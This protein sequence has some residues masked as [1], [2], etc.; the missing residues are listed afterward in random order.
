M[1]RLLP[2]ALLLA[3]C[4]EK[5]YEE[6]LPQIVDFEILFPRGYEV[7]TAE[8]PL[9][10]PSAVPARVPIRIVARGADGQPF[11]QFNGTVRLDV[12][13]GEI[14]RTA[15]RVRVKDGVADA[16]AEIRYAFGPTRI[17]VEDAGEDPEL[18]CANEKDDDEDDLVDAADP[19]CGRARE[20]APAH[21]TQA[22]GISP[23]LRFAEPRIREL[24][25]APRCTTDTPLGG[26]TV[27]IANGKFIVTGTTQAGLYVTDLDGP[28]GGHN[29]VFLFT[30]S[31]PG[32]VRRGDR[33]CS[34]SGNA[35]EF[36]GNTQ[37]NF[38]SFELADTNRNRKID[39][40]D[41]VPCRLV[42]PGDIDVAAL[43]PPV[44]L[45]AEHLLGMG[46]EV[47]ADFY[48]FCAP[49]DAEIP[50][51]EDATDC[52]AARIALGMAARQSPIDCRRDNFAME[53]WEHALVAFDDVTISKHYVECDYNGDERIDRTRGEQALCGE[54]CTSAGCAM[55]CNE[56]E[57][58]K[59]CNEDALCTI[60]GSLKQFGQFGVGV[61]CQGDS[62]RAKF[63][64]ST[65]DT[66]GGAGYDP[67][68]HAGERLT[69]VVGHLRQTQPGPGVETIW[70]VEP[71]D[72]A[73]FISGA[74]Q[75]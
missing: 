40:G 1:R 42:D 53:P 75:P 67:K 10:F 41:I 34:I 3:A 69:R 18:D 6:P 37:L 47:P 32:D 9:P 54:V 28:A 24:Q 55:I 74:P 29:S 49:G 46:G 22:T 72:A 30:H 66:L 12:E 59:A 14:P 23:S 4:G 63:Y 61:G 2:I 56:G 33:L 70:I 45:A 31:S 57:C 48:R 39:D 68:A 52:N 25:L 43:P 5:S 20:P 21:A 51:L 71:R 19:D 36:I 73:D 35:A 58:E 13:P 65:R 7:G 64:V 44:T 16:T 27:T 60:E 17:W 26:E 50:G 11:R 38:P 15:N 8:T 62:C